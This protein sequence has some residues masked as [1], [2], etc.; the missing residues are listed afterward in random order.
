MGPRS[1]PPTRTLS[2]ALV[3]WKL[4]PSRGKVVTFGRDLGNQA[5][6]DLVGGLFEDRRI[7]MFEMLY[8]LE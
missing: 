8:C 4:V 1:K 6:V 3:C 5:P 2:P 7:I